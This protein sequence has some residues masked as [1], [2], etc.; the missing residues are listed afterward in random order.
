MVIAPSGPVA[1]DVLHRLRT[2]P[3][4]TSVHVLHA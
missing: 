4:I 2:S 1:D 3:G